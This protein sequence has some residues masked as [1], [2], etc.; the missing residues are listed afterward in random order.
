MALLV[1]KFSMIHWGDLGQQ[2]VLVS[3]VDDGTNIPPVVPRQAHEYRA[4]RIKSIY[5][6]PVKPQSVVNAF[7][8]TSHSETIRDST[9]SGCA[10]SLFY[11]AKTGRLASV[12]GWSK[13]D[14][15]TVGNISKVYYRTFAQISQHFL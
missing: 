9:S 11:M 7:A 1:F 5:D 4:A 6:T 10:K 13:K 15:S 14:I 2:A 12:T 8:L 3:A